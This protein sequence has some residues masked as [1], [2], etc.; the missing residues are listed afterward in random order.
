MLNIRVRSP[1]VVTL[2]LVV[3]GVVCVRASYAQ[4]TI[5]IDQIDAAK[6]KSDNLI[7]FFVDLRE[8]DG[9]PVKEIDTKSL[10]VLVDEVPIPGSIRVTPFFETGEKISAAIILAS[11][12]DWHVEIEGGFTPFEMEL[13]GMAKFVQELRPIDRVSLWC[14]NER[15]LKP[16][17]AF[18]QAGQKTA[19]DFRKA[20]SDSCKQVVPDA[21]EEEG[22]T[23]EV[24]ATTK[25]VPNLYAEL[26]KAS[27][28][29]LRDELE[30]ESLARH[31][32][33][34]LMSDCND[35]NLKMPQSE[36]K[37]Q[38][39]VDE[40]AT[41]LVEL[42]KFYSIAFTT[43]ETGGI[44]YCAQLSQKTNGVHLQLPDVPKLQDGVAE[45]AKMAAAINRQ[46]V[47]EFTPDELEGGRSVK[48]QM[49]AEVQGTKISTVADQM[50]RLDE[51]SRD[52]RRIL[53]WIGSVLLGLLVLFG[54]F[55]LIKAYINKPKA[56]DPVY[57]EVQ[58]EPVGA[59]K[60]KLSV[61]SGP[62]VGEVYYITEAV[63]T[64]GSGEGNTIVIPD[65]SVSRRH[66]GIKVE[67]MRFELADFGARNGVYVNGRK[68]NKLFLKDGDEIRIG[69]TE[70][71]FTLK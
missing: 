48:F 11:H 21:I 1:L 52:W 69:N 57:I 8:R 58:G 29:R 35:Q 7:R 49:A 65:T 41:E 14:Y 62:A 45:W 42:G 34:I 68:I 6:F 9:Q 43:M 24:Q 63:T 17:L 36:Q 28:E 38:S 60:G 10:S 20:A 25:V 18:T 32:Y 26:L 67:E 39:L 5:R 2:A 31:R 30:K 40:I 15:G 53:I 3:L 19:D 27:R 54:L 13:E 37:I 22:K 66:A 4:Q 47:V 44:P 64:L 51:R 70:M 23:P 71:T 33:V 12:F 50:T 46:L 56:P 61:T 16:V 55:K 59:M